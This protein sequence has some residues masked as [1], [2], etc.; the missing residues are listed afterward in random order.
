MSHD[1]RM[2]PARDPVQVTV[3]ASSADEAARLARM[4]VDGRL[5]A[6][7][8]VSGPITSTYRWEGQVTEAME[9]LCVFKTVA[10]RV[11]ALAAAVRA[12]HSYAVPEILVSAVI[13]GDPD[14]LAWIGAET[15]AGT[16]ED[17]V[18]PGR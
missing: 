4:A 8:Q 14:Y 11:D 6:C 12:A 5:A 18:T 9:W 10:A 7:A 15:S 2:S 13:G 1:R 16:G 3:T 17:G